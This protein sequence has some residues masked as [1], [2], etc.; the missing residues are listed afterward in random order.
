MYFVILKKS[1]VH[2]EI[3]YSNEYMSIFDTTENIL[4]FRPKSGYF[5][6]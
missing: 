5:L 2:L 3:I 1:I 4:I 6:C